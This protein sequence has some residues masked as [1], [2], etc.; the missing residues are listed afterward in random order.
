M[1]QRNVNSTGVS[2]WLIHY[3]ARHA[4]QSF[5]QRLEEEWLADLAERP[6]ELSRLRFAVGCCWATQVIARE[7]QRSAVPVTGTVAA[8]GF[9]SMNFGER[10]HR[11]STLFWVVSLHAAVFYILMTTVLHVP[12]VNHEPLELMPTIDHPRKA[13]TI[14][15]K[16]GFAIDIPKP[17]VTVFRAPDPVQYVTTI[18]EPEPMGPVGPP[19]GTTAHQVLQVQGAPGAGFP[20]PD[21]FYPL[22]AKYLEEQGV[23]TVQVCVDSKGRLTSVPTTLQGTGSSRLD[24]G[25]LKLAT[26]GSGHYRASTEDGRP[27]NSCFPF[28]VRFQL[29]N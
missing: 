26:A 27:V 28:R 9:A 8:T 15:T 11:S 20:N 12:K 7:H 29:K 24:Q 22:S 2:Q 10:P 18:V 14:S 6:S 1:S 25:A 13:F 16:P 17:A 5:A 3:A 4:P 23:A 21:D 19:P